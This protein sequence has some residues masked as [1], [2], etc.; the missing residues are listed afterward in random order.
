MKYSKDLKKVLH[1][2]INKKLFEDFKNYPSTKKWQ[3]RL[4]NKINNFN[5]IDNEIEKNENVDFQLYISKSQNEKLIE[6]EKKFNVKKK[7]IIEY[8]IKEDLKIDYQLNQLLEDI[9]NIKENF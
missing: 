1:T 7:D 6:I 9:N 8:L 5:F 2:N 4:R 3:D